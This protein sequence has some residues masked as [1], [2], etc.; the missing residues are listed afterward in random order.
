MYIHDLAIG[1]K[2]FNISLVCKLNKALYGLEHAYKAKFDRL[3]DTL[4]QFHS[5]LVKHG[6]SPIFYSHT[7]DFVYMLDY[8]DGIIITND[9]P[10]TITSIVSKLHAII[11]FKILGNLTTFLGLMLNHHD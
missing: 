8:V 7:T 1:F 10:T 3:K 11:F 9:N 5:V 2:Y 6:F 4:I